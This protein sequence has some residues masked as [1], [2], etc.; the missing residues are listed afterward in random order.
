MSVR[1]IRGFSL[2]ELTVVTALIGAAMVPITMSITS[3]LDGIQSREY[4]D[5]IERLINQLQQY[6]NNQ[7]TQNNHPGG[8]S[9]WPA[10][11]EHLMSMDGQ[12]WPMCSLADESQRRCQRPDM[13]PWSNDRIGYRIDIATNPSKAM[14]TIPL[15]LISKKERI[16]WASS[17]ARLPYAIVETNGDITIAVSD[18]LISQLYAQFLTKNG[19]TKL[20]DAW[21]VGDHAVI[22]ANRYTVKT[23]A[24]TQ[25]RIDSGTVKEFL[26][27][28]NEKI[29]K[30]MYSCAEG[31]KQTIHVSLNAPMAPNL[32]IE[33]LGIGAW[34]PTA[35]D[36]GDYWELGLE[37]NAKIKSTGRWEKMNSGYLNVRLKCS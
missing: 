33:Y 7:I 34:K 10:T 21:D 15:S 18:P 16:K 22:N 30:N 35:T 28:H 25:Q 17:L 31:M 5:Y 20:T 23:V 26:G 29:Y 9:V 6:Q 3:Y 1:K 37:Y 24:G 27:V 13:V 12:F 32:S 36:K 11:L 14:L 8:V 2:I 4:S 19:N